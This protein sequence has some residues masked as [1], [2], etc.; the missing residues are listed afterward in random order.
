LTPAFTRGSRARYL[1]LLREAGETAPLDVLVVGGGINGA[2]TLRDLALRA[3]DSGKALRLALVEKR[4]FASG[5]SG[6]NSQ[7]LHGGLRYLKNFEFS[8]VKEALKE[9]AALLRIAPHLAEAVPFLIPFYGLLDKPYYGA[10][11]MTYD[12]LAGQEN[13]GRREFL[14]REDV[15]ARAPG[16]REE[17][18][19]SGGVYFDAR[20]NSA[21]LVL[22]NLFDAARDGAWV[23]NYVEALE[24]KRDADSY[25]VRM[26]ETFAG[27]EFEVWARRLVDARGPWDSSGSV[28]LV[29]GS[30]LVF[31]RLTPTDHAI[32]HFHTDGRIFFVI[33]WGPNQTRS[34][35][36][37]T[38]A[39]H[40]GTADDVRPSAD[41]VRYM[42]SI[43]EHLFPHAR[44]VEPVGAYSALR[45]LVKSGHASATKTS[46]EHKIFEDETGV[47]RITGGKYTTYRAM[48]AEAADLAWPELAGKCRTAEVPLGGNAPDAVAEE[49]VRIDERAARTG[50][51]R[52]D[53]AY[54]TALF[55]VQTG[56]V[57]EKDPGEG[58]SRERVLTA[59]LHW[60]LEHEMVERMPDFL[61]VSTYLGHEERWSG[62]DLAS[63]AADMGNAAGWDAERR[64]EEVLLTE[65]LLDR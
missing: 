14:S 42:K 33:P 41:E 13:I 2:G 52:S 49:K 63:L 32:A 31:P 3:K 39:D 7:L 45:P 25:R 37:T 56:A 34:L 17:G 23:L 26:R 50:L 9:R 48:S 16:L 18:L 44:G 36:G 64:R 20:V 22:E 54:L 5:T 61:F 28:R 11:L 40:Q 55:G 53:V 21:R 10:G 27:A 59:V 12:V 1:K 30:H 8:L 60:C 35:V 58:E 4:H 46:R 29:R 19:R 24:W 65:R 6:R 15:L 38:D 43:V 57:M 62:E 51:Y 47:I